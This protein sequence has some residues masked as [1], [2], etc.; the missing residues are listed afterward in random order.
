[1]KIIYYFINCSYLRVI[2]TATRQLTKTAITVTAIFIVALGY[3]LWYYVLGYSGITE[4]K[5]NSPL[6]KIGKL[7]FNLLS[8]YNAKD[9]LFIHVLMSYVS[10]CSCSVADPRAA[11]PARTPL[12]TKIFLISC[13]FLGKSGKFV[14]WSPLLEGWCPLL[15]E[16]L[17]PSLG[18][19]RFAEIWTV[20]Q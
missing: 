13:S 18:C 3:D 1:M 11:P 5:M 16:I 8:M 4:Y 6:Q 12:W 20:F 9:S 15:R 7:S 19:A 10:S 14:C 17:D 2:D